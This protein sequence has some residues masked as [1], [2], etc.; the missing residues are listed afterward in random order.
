MSHTYLSTSAIGGLLIFATLGA[1]EAQTL[2]PEA[3]NPAVKT[4][5]SACMAD[6]QR[7][8][9][10]IVPGGGRIVRCLASK[11][12]ELTPPCRDSMLKAKAALER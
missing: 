6:A 1:A 7:L 3:S 5:V 4:A 9:S 11:Q 2:P 10:G 12:A 8:C